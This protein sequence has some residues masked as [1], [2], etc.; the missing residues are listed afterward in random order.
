[1]AP[2][3]PP[4]AARQVA[5]AHGGHL[6]AF[7]QRRS[8]GIGQQCPWDLITFDDP[9][10]E[11]LSAAAW[12]I[13]DAIM[14]AR[15]G[16]DTPAYDLWRN[17]TLAGT[18]LAEPSKSHV[19]S[20]AKPVFRPSPGKLKGKSHGVPGYVSEWLWYLLTAELPPETDRTVEILLVPSTTVT[21]SGV[22]GFII[23]R[24]TGTPAQFEYRMWE[25]KKYTG[26]DDDVDPTI[27]GAWQQLH[28]NGADYL[29]AIAWGDKHL[30]PDSRG[31]IST[32]VPRWLNADPSSNGGVSVAI[33]ESATPDKAFHTSHDHLPTHTH[34][35]ALN[36]LIVAVDDFEAFAT[37]VREYVWTAL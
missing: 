20:Y 21:D 7:I 29:A 9:T 31:F 19:L 37:T 26:A 6:S 16:L 1:M 14:R 23:H 5:D 36:G 35:G 10:D 2:N 27:R 34:P 32:L 24:L 8:Q 13:A 12:I 28:T 3:I 4:E 18:P 33:N 22:D 15:T 30:A 17:A 25:T 11:R